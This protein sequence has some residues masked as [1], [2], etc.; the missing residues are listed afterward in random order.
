M[1]L[2]LS[3]HACR[4]I[5][6]RSNTF[7][8]HL[9]AEIINQAKNTHLYS[10]VSYKVTRDMNYSTNSPILFVA[11]W[12][13]RVKE[14]AA[15]PFRDKDLRADWQSPSCNRGRVGRAWNDAGGR[16]ATCCAPAVPRRWSPTSSYERHSPSSRTRFAGSAPNCNTR[17]E[18]LAL[19]SARFD[20]S[21]K[22]KKKLFS[23]LLK[24][25]LTL[26]RLY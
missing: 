23:D 26:A 9:L 22:E 15:L 13:K 12:S 16:R 24:S 20:N 10:A 19:T 21:L 3:R 7:H 18:N 2:I 25:G 6:S 14:K 5:S 1:V 11:Q 8:I 17:P 4:G